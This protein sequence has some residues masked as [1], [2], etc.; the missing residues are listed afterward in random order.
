[1]IKNLIFDLGGVIINL[2]ISRSFQQFALLGDMTLVQMNHIAE[3]NPLFNNYE[4]GLITSFQFRMGI[5]EILK[6][7]VTDKEIDTAWNAMLLDIPLERLKFLERL[8]PHYKM[9]VLSNTNEIHITEFDKIAKKVFGAGNYQLL[10]DTIYYS[11]LVNMRK[12]DSEIYQFVLQENN[13][14]AEETLYLEDNHENI[15][16][17]KKL[18][19]ITY[20]VPTN[21]LD[22]NFLENELL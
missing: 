13:I 9:L 17:S 2:D 10:F 1:M 12:P 20:E 3:S 21:Q 16:S 5:R 7:D 22:L 8:K 18:G 15:V 11:H 14:K 4:K 19:F 6:K